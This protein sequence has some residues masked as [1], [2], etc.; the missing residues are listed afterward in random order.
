MAKKIGAFYTAEGISHTDK[1]ACLNTRYNAWWN[2][3]SKRQHTIIL[4]LYEDNGSYPG[5]R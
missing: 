2:I 1:T 5:A 3:P 4:E